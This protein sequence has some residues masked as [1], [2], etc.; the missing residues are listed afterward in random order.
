M[1][2]PTPF[3]TAPIFLD[4]MCAFWPS[5]VSGSDYVSTYRSFQEEEGE[6]GTDLGVARKGEDPNRLCCCRGSHVVKSM[7][8]VEREPLPN[9][10][11]GSLRSIPRP[12]SC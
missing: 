5:C 9:P 6:V 2:F 8:M 1:F 12:S 10:M 11:P 7:L 4:M 3:L